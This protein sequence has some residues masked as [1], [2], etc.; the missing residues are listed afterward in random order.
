M[1][2]AKTAFLVDALPGC[3]VELLNTDRIRY[4]I[5]SLNS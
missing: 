1:G 5:E 3:V 2:Q 4:L